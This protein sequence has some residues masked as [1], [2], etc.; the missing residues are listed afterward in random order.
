MVDGGV[1]S[2]LGNGV[3]PGSFSKRSTK[4]P[5]I[6]PDSNATPTRT[7]E[8]NGPMS[9]VVAKIESTPV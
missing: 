9:A 1:D 2:I 5:A 6:I 8:N 7:P 4:A 3:F